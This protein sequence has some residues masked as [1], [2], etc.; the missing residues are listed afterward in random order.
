MR[1]VGTTLFPP[2]GAWLN[3]T[4][5]PAGT[6]KTMQNGRGGFEFL[7][8]RGVKDEI[9][10]FDE[11]YELLKDKLWNY[12]DAVCGEA[13][14]LAMGLLFVGRGNATA[15]SASAPRRRSWRW[16]S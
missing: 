10:T 1:K 16:T 2:A 14:A 6:I 3:T 5:V 8:N 12:D 15:T 7:G 9:L 4:Q 13:S 11:L